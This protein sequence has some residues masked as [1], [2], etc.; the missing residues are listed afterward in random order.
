MKGTY[1]RIGI[2]VFLSAIALSIAVSWAQAE[3]KRR[4]TV[5]YK[6][7]E[8]S[9]VLNN[10]YM[11]FAPDARWGPYEQPHRLVFFDFTWRDIEES[12]GVYT[13]D[14]LEEK[15]QFKKWTDQNVKIIFRLILDDP[16]DDRHMDIPDWLYEEIGKEGSWY[17]TSYGQGFSPNYENKIL[18]E[19]HQKLIRKLGERYNRDARIA[20]I[21]LG[22][23]GHWGEWH[24]KDGKGGVKEPF[25]KLAVTD[26]YVNAYIHEFPDK[27][28]LM[29]RPHEIAKINH[30]GLY[31]DVFGDNEETRDNFIKWIHNGYTS[32][33]TGEKM[34][35]MPEH[36]IYAPSGGEFA[37]SEDDSQ[38]ISNTS[39]E[40]TLA[41]ARESHTT[42]LGPNIPSIETYGDKYQGNIDRLLNTMGYRYVIKTEAHQAKIKPNEKLMVNMV[43][44]NKGVAPFYFNW[45]LELSLA[46][47][48]GKI[49]YREN[50]QADIRSWLPGLHKS[51]SSLKLPAM[52]PKGE[53]ALCIAILDPEKGTPGVELAIQGK[54]G[55]GR[56]TLGKVNVE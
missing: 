25:P 32:W 15:H 31:N 34:P 4:A 26:Q 9:S 28:L 20:F 49:V 47:Q 2:I 24:T 7:T 33:L 29:R 16:R 52:L 1:K 14:K 6:P 13:F 46:D 50:V 51:T 55:D 22:S 8:I 54:R 17:T 53:Y 44:E 35:A 42:W 21:E 37:S 36:W 11:G 56:Y 41:Q 3:V 27:P 18:I 5:T 12:K 30:I 19:E 45:P 40:E 43:I 39:I 10:P 48:Q 38:Y 23:I